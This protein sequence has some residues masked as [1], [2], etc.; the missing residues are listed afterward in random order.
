MWTFGQIPSGIITNEFKDLSYINE[1]F[2]DPAMTAKWDEVYG[3]IYN[4]GG[5]VDYR[6]YQPPWT[7][8]IIDL[9]GLGASGAS[10]YKMTSGKILPYH[11]DAYIKYIKHHKIKDYKMIHR[12]VIFLEDWQ[13][14]HIFE[15]NG[16]PLYHYKAGT[17]VMWQYDTPHMAA[18]LGPTDRYTLQITG[19]K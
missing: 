12:A 19:I 18:N 9:L 8:S 1:P 11:A 2:N 10:F 7:D 5:M 15:I 3:P 4:T 17:Y 6:H 16:M 14:G 13:P